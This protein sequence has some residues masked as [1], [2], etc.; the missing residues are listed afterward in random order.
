MSVVTKKKALFM[1]GVGAMGAAITADS[2]MVSTDSEYRVRAAAASC[3]AAA[4]AGGVVT[5]F[6]Q[7]IH[8]ANPPTSG[9]VELL[10]PVGA[11]IGT[12]VAMVLP[13]SSLD[14][15]IYGAMTGGLLLI[16]YWSPRLD[17]M[18]RAG[19]DLSER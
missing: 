18:G 1:A 6:R 13:K 5:L 7:R 4:V 15:V 9:R 8:P 11:V 14:P 10:G 19:Q 3:I 12:V 16:V 17:G 2:I